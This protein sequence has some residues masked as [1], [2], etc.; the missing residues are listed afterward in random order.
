[1]AFSPDASKLFLGISDVTYSSLLQ[2]K[3]RKP[4]AEALQ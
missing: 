2:Y 4:T 3:Q 1:M